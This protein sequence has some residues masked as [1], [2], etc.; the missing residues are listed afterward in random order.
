MAVLATALVVAAGSLAA[1]GGNPPLTPDDPGWPG[2]WAARLIGVPQVW[3]LVDPSAH[4][5]IASIDTGVDAAFPDLKDVVVP[6]W[7]IINNDADTSDHAGHGTD[8]AIVAAANADNGYGIAGVCPMCRIMPVK[9][10]N[11]GTSG[12]KLIAAGIRWAVD[13]GA[14]IL[15][16]SMVHPLPD[17]V[18]QAAVDYANAHGAI[19]I[20]SVGNLGNTTVGYP[21]GLSGVVSVTAT[22]TSDQLY[23]WATRGQWVDLA[24][25]GC[26]YEEE[27]CG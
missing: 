18:E 25:P 27:L 11:D 4:P 9:V 24:A 15:I 22:D 6:G 23:P 17:P 16:V 19:L 7:D 20:A 26:E 1:G 21:A 12:P 10:S 2:Q 5:V 8:V 13:N 3:Q 14:R